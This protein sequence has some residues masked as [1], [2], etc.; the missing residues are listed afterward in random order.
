VPPALFLGPLPVTRALVIGGIAAGP[1]LLADERV[2][3]GVVALGLGVPVALI[4]ARALHGLSRR[5]LVVVPA[6]VV[7]VDPMTLSE[8]VLFVR[9]QVRSVRPLSPGASLPDRAVD[10]RLGASLGTLLID[11][12]EDVELVQRGRGRRAGEHRRAPR[13]LIAVVQPRQLLTSAAR[14]VKVEA[15]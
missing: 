7:V 4:A 3:A 15:T 10:L 9:R 2:V 1:L 13:L 8:P 6:G 14:R 11:L 5:W 12:D